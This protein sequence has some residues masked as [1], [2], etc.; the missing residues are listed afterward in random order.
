MLICGQGHG[1]ETATIFLDGP[2]APG[3]TVD[4]SVGGVGPDGSTIYV[5]EAFETVTT[6]VDGSVIVT[7]IFVQLSTFF[8]LL[9]LTACY[10]L[11]RLT[12]FQ[13]EVT[14][15]EGSSQFSAYFTEISLPYT[16]QDMCSMSDSSLQCVETGYS[17]GSAFTTVTYSAPPYY[18]T[19]TFPATTASSTFPASSAASST[20]RSA[21]GVMGGVIG[22]V[23][24]VIAVIALLLFCRRRRNT[25]HIVTVE[26]AKAMQPELDS[27][28]MENSLP[29][30][31]FYPSLPQ[32]S[33]TEG[34]N[35]G[36]RQVQ[37]NPHSISEMDTRYQTAIETPERP[38]RY[39]S[40]PRPMW[41]G[42]GVRSQS[43]RTEGMALGPS[44]ANSSMKPLPS[45]PRT[46]PDRESS[47]VAGG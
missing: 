5:I 38:P 19:L 17:S 15:Q 8:S 32:Q 18:S 21:I 13:H 40:F 14:I 12:I 34:R 29:Q 37:Y 4:I 45:V 30:A 28:A 10:K 39:A 43:T 41:T 20:A 16:Y 25:D 1:N 26:N 11:H 23:V 36:P 27:S 33:F 42:G 47:V 3:V 6:T 44:L 31:P 35:P 24:F 7:P 46:G 9:L 2:P 22:S